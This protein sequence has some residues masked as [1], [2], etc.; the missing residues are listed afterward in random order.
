LSLLRI[1]GSRILGLRILGPRIPGHRRRTAFFFAAALSLAPGAAVPARSQAGNPQS[2]QPAVPAS[3]A[4][5]LSV[6]PGSTTSNLRAWE[7]LNVE[8]VNFEGV[9]RLRL[10]PLP[11][12]LP[13]QPGKPLNA[14]DVRLS[15][16]RLFATGLYRGIEVEGIRHGDQVTIVFK[17][18]Q[19]LFLG[20][21]TVDGMKNDRLTSQLAHA[22]RL[23]PG[24]TFS[25]ARLTQADA[26]VKQMLEENGFY[27]ATIAHTTRVKS[28]EDQINVHYQIA[29]GPQA[30]VGEVKVEGD[31]GMPIATFRKK[32]KLKP[33]SKVT[34]DTVNNALNNLRKNYQK[35]QRLEG[36]VALESKQYRPAANLLD[37]S[38]QANQGPLV[39]IRVD[40]VKLS[41]GKVKTLVPV[42]QEGAVD[43]DLLNE[44]DRRLRDYY[45]RDGYF[46]T[47]VTHKRTTEGTARTLIEYAVNLGERHRV[48]S[49]TLTGNKY[50]SNDILQPR[51]GVV[52]T[53]LF[54]RHGS[55]SQ[56]LVQADVNNLTALYQSN[57]FSKV[58]VTPL[59]KR[60]EGGEGL[61]VTYQVDEGTQQKI[62]KYQ[63]AGNTQIPTGELTPLLNL[64]TGQ[65][66][67]A[68]NILGDR[69][70]I[71]TY[72]FK[73][74]FSQASVA[75]EQKPE[76]KDADDI[77]VAMN[78][79]EGQQTFVN[80]VLI[81]GLHFTR[82]DTVD[83]HI[84]L[85]KGDPLDNSALLEMQRKLY[86]LTLFNEVTAAIQNPNGDEERKNVLVQFNEAKRWDLSYGG[87]FQLQTGNPTSNCPNVPT[88]QA[89]PTCG[90]NGNGKTGASALVLFDV[91]RINLGGRNQSL[92]LRTAYGTLEQRATLVYSLPHIF[93]NPRLDFSLSGGYTNSQDVT[94]YAA[95]R[96]EGT[97]RLTE[98]PTKPNT[99][100]YSFTYR[101]VKVDP[102]SVQVAPDE[103]PLI[104]EPVRVGG[105]G[106]TW[107]HDTR[108]P[109]PLDAQS[110]NYTTADEFFT[111][112][113]F[114]S[115]ANFNRLDVTNASYYP[116]G[117]RRY[118]LARLTRFGYERSFGA[119]QYRY[120]PLP[121]RLYAGGAQSLRGFSINSAGPRDSLTG[122]PIGGAGAFVNS[123]EMRF[124]NPQLPYFGSAIGFVLFHDTGNVFNNSSDIWPSLL[125]TKQPHS[126]TCGGPYLTVEA[127]S[128]VTRSSS[129]NP[130]GTCSFNNFSHAVGLGLRYHTP[131]GPLRLDFSYNLN[132]PI[133]PVVITYGTLPNGQPIPPHQGQAGHFN[134]F[135]SIGQ[136]F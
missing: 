115:E 59:V 71:L 63:V 5:P 30:R 33:G 49:V 99:L 90:N 13:V 86:D 96:L 121:E 21:V 101:R 74:G 76:A 26:E 46:D 18:T 77:D 65:P 57:G 29:S 92:T 104:S 44:G 111:K 61:S 89:P 48:E 32:G 109:S 2:T 95:S 17:G 35:Q 55:Y 110:G 69:D 51:L 78:I 12:Q 11:A 81:S 134:F 22:T 85:H 118:V 97:V 3:P 80:R 14:Q 106:I 27:K 56:A 103:I 112:N 31:S 132:P 16:R 38:F 119:D 116:L 129:T 68:A 19:T 45:Q 43:D 40:G 117:K 105:P 15:L 125:R 39:T 98:R 88:G 34:R 122:F 135:F 130:T 4:A 9:D 67:S 54:Q 7:G 50:F 102:N 113:I 10:E 36:N 1:L 120:I 83:P 72:Y 100:I 47:Q 24:M 58:K 91:S 127:Q 87:G 94:T 23:N 133:Y 28:E 93:N 6:T 53:N 126:Y 124:P 60:T 123:T 84:L 64:E 136:A 42:Y 107:I 79:T 70:S 41:K 108:R 37:Y 114:S 62:G 73:H 52:K 131:I 66:Y 82:P 8:A 25:D 75:I 128:A 20:R